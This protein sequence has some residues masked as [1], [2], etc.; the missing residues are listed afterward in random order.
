MVG[1]NQIASTEVSKA[2]QASTKLTD[3]FETFLTLL[4]TQ[5]QNQDPLEPTDP[6]EFTNQLV[7]FTE[8]EQSIAANKNLEQLV[9]MANRNE[10]S[11]AVSLIG[12]QI[13]ATES[14]SILKNGNA[15]WNYNLEEPAEEVSIRIL[16]DANVTVFST[17]GEKTIGTHSLNWNG[18]DNNGDQSPDGKYNIL[19]SAIGKDGKTINTK[20]N[21]IGPVDS[22]FSQ[23]GENMV[24]VGGITI[25]LNKIISVKQ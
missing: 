3:N 9:S 11:S 8:V 6:S 10:L 5:L 17:S 18:V 7:Q 24:D 12:K 16:N 1:I 4:T 21:M 14:R 22:V 15:K 25:P 2:V 19:V 23:E 13:E 20:T